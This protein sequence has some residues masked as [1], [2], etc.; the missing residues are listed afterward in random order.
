MQWR[1]PQQ[2][3]APA[4]AEDETVS[5]E[6]K[7]KE[8]G[9]E[10]EAFRTIAKTQISGDLKVLHEHQFLMPIVWV[11]LVCAGLAAPLPLSKGSIMA[12]QEIP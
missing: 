9:N 6:T 7:V 2:A 12:N 3:G 1:K 4:K 8:S 10:S 11:A 5:W